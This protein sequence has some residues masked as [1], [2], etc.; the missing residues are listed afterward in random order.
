M[1]KLSADDKLKR[2]FL[3][4]A[5]ALFAIPSY[6][7]WEKVVVGHQ[8]P[9][10][11]NGWL[12]LLMFPAFS[13]LSFVY[14]IFYRRAKEADD[15]LEKEMKNDTRRG[16]A[17]YAIGISFMFLLVGIQLLESHILKHEPIQTWEYVVV[18][19]LVLMWAG[20]MILGNK[21]DDE[22]LHD[23]LLKNNLRWLDRMI[24]KDTFDDEE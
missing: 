14:A 9:D 16:K 17:I 8:W 19:L 18:P 12:G 4:F 3:F 24:F 2:G 7:F 23:F 20:C 5:G 22:K 1:M 11:F 15:R 6:L 21:V 10:D 13:L